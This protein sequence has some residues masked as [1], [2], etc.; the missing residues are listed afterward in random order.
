MSQE[1]KVLYDGNFSLVEITSESGE[2]YLIEGECSRCGKCCM[3]PLW[4]AGYNDENG[5]CTK[6]KTDIVDGITYYMCSIYNNRPV[7]CLLWPTT[8]EEIQAIPECTLKINKK[9]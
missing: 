9:S 7:S 1:L 2:T 4:N 6:L 3:Y 5:V 8:I